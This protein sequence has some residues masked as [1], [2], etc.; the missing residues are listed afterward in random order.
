[1]KVLTPEE[2][3]EKLQTLPNVGQTGTIWGNVLKLKPG[4][5]LFVPL[6]EYAG[7][8]RLQS[9]IRGRAN[10]AG[11]EVSVHQLANGE[12]WLIRRNG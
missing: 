6:H 7:K 11:I 3:Q 1:M 5:S 4:E 8:S 12:G 10:T 2:T 9:A